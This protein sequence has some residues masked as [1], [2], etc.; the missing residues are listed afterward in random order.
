[1][2]HIQKLSVQQSLQKQTDYREQWGRGSC[3]FHLYY[4]MRVI[5]DVWLTPNLSYVVDNVF[6]K[7]LCV[8]NKL[9]KSMLFI[10]TYQ[11]LMDWLLKNNIIR[12][13]KVLKKRSRMVTKSTQQSWA[14]QNDLQ[15][16][17]L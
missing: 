2:K 9:S 17:K 10:L 5:K 1:M 7:K 8:I 11:T 16:Q 14:G 4:A 12:T 13:S 6:V 3:Y 15:Q